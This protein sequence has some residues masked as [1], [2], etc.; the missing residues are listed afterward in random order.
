MPG[1]NILGYSHP[2]VDEAVIKIIK[3]GN[4]STLNAP[5]EVELAE[6]LINL[7]H[8]FKYKNSYSRLEISQKRKAIEEVL[9]CDN[10]DTHELRLK[11]AGFK[12]FDLWLQH[13]NFVSYIAI[14]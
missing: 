8:D 7:H 14:K 6:Q 2:E 11:K 1:T 9:I 10:K 4:M 3:D 13:F 5:E 12:N